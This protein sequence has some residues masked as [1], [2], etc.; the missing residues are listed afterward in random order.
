MLTLLV[1]ML[2]LSGGVFAVPPDGIFAVHRETTTGGVNLP[3]GG[4]PPVVTL[5][6]DAGKY[7]VTAKLLIFNMSAAPHEAICTLRP[8]GTALAPYDTITVRLAPRGQTGETHNVVLH[9]VIELRAPGGV[10]VDCGHTGQ[11]GD[12]RADHVWLTA[13]ANNKVTKIE[14]P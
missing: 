6:L 14:L 8:Q 2:G 12:I 10:D 7:L 1:V 13:L 11:V 4:L 9:S 5:S 3:P